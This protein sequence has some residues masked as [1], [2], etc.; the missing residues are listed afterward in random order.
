MKRYG[1]H[2]KRILFIALFLSQIICAQNYLRIHYSDGNR[3]DIPIAEKKNWL[4]F[5]NGQQ[6]ILG[7][8]DYKSTVKA[9]LENKL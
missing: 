7:T 2:R 6:A 5:K 8:S 3:T 4:V 9:Y 1:S